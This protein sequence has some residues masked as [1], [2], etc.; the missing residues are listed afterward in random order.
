MRIIGIDIVKGSTAV[1]NNSKVFDKNGHVK[2]VDNEIC[3]YCGRN[4]IY[5]A[6]HPTRSNKDT[7]VK[8]CIDHFLPKDQYPYLAMCYYNLIPSCTSCNNSFINSFCPEVY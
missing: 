4:Y 6:C 2:R 5:Y 1:I 8:P 3:P 7:M